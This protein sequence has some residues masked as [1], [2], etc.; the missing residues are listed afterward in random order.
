MSITNLSNPVLETTV[1]IILSVLASSGFWAYLMNRREKND[2]RTQLIVGLAHDRIVELG[3]KY[4][5][6]G[7]VT[8]D[9][10]ENLRE[11]LYT[12]YIELS[13]SDAIKRIMANVD[14]LPIKPL[15]ELKG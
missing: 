6:R 5:E 4:I 12:P 7:Y 14:K 8:Q 9:E 2:A 3:I 15:T 1:T 10:Y 11:Y 13:D